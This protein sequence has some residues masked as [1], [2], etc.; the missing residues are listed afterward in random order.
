MNEKER[1]T[2]RKKCREAKLQSYREAEDERNKEIE[3]RE[4][5]KQRR[6]GRDK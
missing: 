2:G 1:K 6:F 4:T 3:K 5:Q